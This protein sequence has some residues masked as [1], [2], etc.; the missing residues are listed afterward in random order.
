MVSL[1]GARFGYRAATGYADLDLRRVSLADGNYVL[2]VEVVPGIFRSTK[3]YQLSG[4]ATGNRVVNN[5]DRSLSCGRWA[6]MSD[7]LVS[8]SMP[9]SM[10]TT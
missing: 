10:A 3:F 8:T 7:S 2:I 4:D 5:S 9:I 1:S 6:R